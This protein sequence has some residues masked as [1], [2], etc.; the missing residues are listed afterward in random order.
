M[1]L[2][3]APRHGPPLKIL[4]LG[5][6]RFIG[7]HMTQQ[8]VARGHTVTLFNRG[9]TNAGRFS[10]LEQLIGDRD[11]QLDALKRRK[12]DAVIDNSGYVPRVVRLSAELL[13]PQVKHYVFV[14]TISVYPDF[15][16]PRTESSPVG[17]LSDPTV[18]KVDSETYGPLKVLCEEAVEASFAGRATI[19]RPGLI[20][21]PEDST[22]R[23]TYWPARAARGGEILT[24]G[25]AT[26]GIQFIDARD[27]AAFTLDVIEQNTYGTFNALSPPG[28][29]TMG[30]L[31]GSC[32]AAVNTLV[33]PT[34]PPRPLWVPAE[35]LQQQKVVPWVDMP[36][37]SP[38]TGDEAAFAKTSSAAAVKAGLRITSMIRTV[39][40]TLV[41]HQ[42]RPEAERTKLKAGISPDREKEVLAAWQ[43]AQNQQQ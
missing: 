41:W 37:W 8:A 26:D 25:S 13:A 27:L 1:S 38:A 15:S 40:D 23:F 14:S 31:M 35:F 24:P 7:I 32:V 4:I 33:K 18:E 39:S 43:L 21:G 9:K 28:M 10:D 29:F 36:V 22:D 16:V 3:A 12:W 34:P 2:R 11:G 5:G 17:T 19:L 30:D 42:Q 20:V 6:T